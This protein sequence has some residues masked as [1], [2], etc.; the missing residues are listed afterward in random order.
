M[1]ARRER[2]GRSRADQGTA[3]Q[4]HELATTK[5]QTFIRDLGRTDI[6]GSLDDHLYPV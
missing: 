5:V 3:R 6:P 2:S 1:T 4:A